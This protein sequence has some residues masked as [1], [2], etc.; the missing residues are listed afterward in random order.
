MSDVM[1]DEAVQA[2]IAGEMFV[3]SNLVSALAA[4]ATQYTAIR[5]GGA[6]LLVE[7]RN[8]GTT[9]SSITV[10]FYENAPANAGGTPIVG[11]NR[12]RTPGGLLM[13]EPQ[14][15]RYGVTP[16]GALPSP[17]FTLNFSD[18]NKIS[19][20]FGDPNTD[21]LELAAN[22]DYLFAV[23]NND[24]SPRDFSWSWLVRRIAR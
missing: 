9:A 15:V 1:R 5:I 13:P 4:G 11:T 19:A 22:T 2:T 7:R 24:A 18:T 17:L 8:Y 14:S 6:P 3:Y 21:K 10:N 23:T 16:S 12:N 20:A